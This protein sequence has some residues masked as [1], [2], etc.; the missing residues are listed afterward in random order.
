MASQAFGLTDVAGRDGLDQMRE[1]D[2]QDVLRRDHRIL[3]RRGASSWSVNVLLAHG[4]SSTRRSNRLSNGR[5]A[6]RRPPWT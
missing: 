6:V 1:R 5:E 2:A 3:S 4:V